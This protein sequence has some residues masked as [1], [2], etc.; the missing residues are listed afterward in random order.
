VAF[1]ILA[2]PFG[3]P[4]L[5]S[6]IYRLLHGFKIQ[7]KIKTHFFSGASISGPKQLY[8]RAII[9]YNYVD[10]CVL[11]LY[12][13]MLC[14]VMLYEQLNINHVNFDFSQLDVLLNDKK[15]GLIVYL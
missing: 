6:Q 2:L 15:N 1:D 11:K 9:P 13:G 3:I 8:P 14:Y 5:S 12:Y 4:P 10:L 7:Y